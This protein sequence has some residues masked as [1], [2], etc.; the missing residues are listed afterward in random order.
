MKTTAEKQSKT[1]KGRIKTLL[2]H[3]ITQA[4]MTLVTLYAL[5]GD[6]LRLLLFPIGADQTFLVL[7]ILAMF[8]F[9]AELILSSIGYNGYF[10]SFFF[11]LDLISTVSL[12]TDIEPVML[13]LFSIFIDT[14]GNEDSVAQATKGARLARVV[15]LIRLVRVVKLYKTANK[16]R[17]LKEDKAVEINQSENMMESSKIE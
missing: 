14:D 5:L 4:F 13:F 3:K 11:W 1:V 6:D 10:K 7:T 15:R 12:L 16:A 9:S 8:L 17:K 2:D